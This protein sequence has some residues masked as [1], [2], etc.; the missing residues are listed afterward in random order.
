M[1]ICAVADRFCAETGRPFSTFPVISWTDAT[2]GCLDMRRRPGNLL[3][4]GNNLI[5]DEKAKSSD[6]SCAKRCH[7][8]IGDVTG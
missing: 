3:V 8:W 6:I 4:S 2:S 5:R 1:V 7:Q